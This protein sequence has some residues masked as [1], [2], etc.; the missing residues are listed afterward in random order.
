[1][2]QSKQTLRSSCPISCGL[3]ILGDK[4][5]LLIIRDLLLTNRVEYG[6]L[7]NAGEGISTNILSDRL[8]Q[9][10]KDGMITKSKHPE[11]GK[12]FIYSL[13]EKGV[14]LA[15]VII[16]L[17]I[18]ADANIDGAK[19]PEMLVNFLKYDKNDLMQKLMAGEVK[20]EFDF[21]K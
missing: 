20:Y 17:A 2:I 10:Q 6:H 21:S 19:L 8:A 3:D 4:W 15:P 5:T 18:W 12:K 16:E 7:L 13:T 9:L 1:M 14:R 11:H